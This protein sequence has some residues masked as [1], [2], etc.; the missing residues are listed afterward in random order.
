M[1]LVKAWAAAVVM[2]LVGN[3]L[4][5][6]ITVAGAGAEAVEPGSMTHYMWSLIPTFVLYL[7]TAALGALFHR[8][9]GSAARHVAAVLGV[10]AVALVV[11]TV[12]Y[13]AAGGST[14]ID[15]F[16]SIVVAVLGA[17]AGWQAV[18]RLRPSENAQRDAYF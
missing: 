4:V 16:T 8:G 11:S 1:D 13:L 17:V 10:P 18:D 5:G 3:I 6:W 12:G 15:T 9:A 2:F 7:L 14:V